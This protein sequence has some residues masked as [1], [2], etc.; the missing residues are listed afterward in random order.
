VKLHRKAIQTT[1][2]LISLMVVIAMIAAYKMYNKPHRSVEEEVALVTSAAQLFD[3]FEKS[4]AEANKK[5]LDKVVEV[6]GSVSE[7][8]MN[9]DH[10]PIVVLETGNMMFGVRCTMSESSVTAKTGSVVTIKGI[11]KGYLSD[12]VIT[13]GI[14]KK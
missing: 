2:A 6:T 9:M 7:V 8:S 1:I 14:L 12:V 3:A 10:K 5:Y 11:C 4:E 13:N